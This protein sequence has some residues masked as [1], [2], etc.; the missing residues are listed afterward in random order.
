MLG[1]REGEM[2]KSLIPLFIK[3]L[4]SFIRLH[5]HELISEV[6]KTSHLLI[7]SHSVQFS[8]S[9]VS[10]SVTPWTAAHQ[11][12]LS[13][14]NSRSLLKL[15][16]IESV[17]PTNHLI[18]C[19]PLLLLPS[20]VT[21]VVFISTQ[22]FGRVVAADINIQFKILPK[23]KPRFWFSKK[24]NEFWVRKNHTLSVTNTSCIS[25]SPLNSTLWTS[26]HIN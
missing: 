23:G 14:T 20:V 13:I 22:E 10:D 26:L 8:H 18:L 15:M 4:I 2:E 7:S 16:S 6:P 5:P 19:H 25:L 9:V 12:S 21:L 17:M 1:G 3:T 24:V 11:T